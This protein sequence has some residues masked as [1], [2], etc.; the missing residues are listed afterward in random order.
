MGE[1]I[2]AIVSAFV[3]IVGLTVTFYTVRRADLRREEVLRWAND[4]IR[5]L[6]S[7]LIS[8]ILW[9]EKYFETASRATLLSAVTDTS[10]LVEQGRIFFKNEIIDSFGSD[11]PKAY[12]GYRPQILDALVLAHQ[13]ACNWHGASPSDRTKMTLI[14]EQAIRE[15]V[16][17]VQSEIGRQ[18]TASTDVRTG[19]R[20][21]NLLQM[22]ESRTD[23]PDTRRKSL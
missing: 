7:L 13:L 10:V 16:S 2:A 9:D 20:G 4:A 14:L 23:S 12:R 18:R 17:L 15:F 8:C 3:A 19:G 1:T 6:Q 11:K 5:T 22:V 21:V